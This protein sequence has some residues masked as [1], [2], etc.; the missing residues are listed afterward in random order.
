MIHY[1]IMDHDN[2]QAHV[3]LVDSQ[4]LIRSCPELCHLCICSSLFHAVRCR[5]FWSSGLAMARALA[6]GHRG[7]AGA[8]CLELGAGLGL[9]GLAAARYLQAAKVV[10]TDLEDSNDLTDLTA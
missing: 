7:I 4:T 5:Q 3:F 9:V 2:I 1:I 6:G 8:R 10:L